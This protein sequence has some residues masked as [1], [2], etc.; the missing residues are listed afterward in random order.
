MDPFD[1]VILSSLYLS[2]LIPEVSSYERIR[3]RLP[4][5]KQIYD[6]KVH[7]LSGKGFIDKNDKSKLTFIGRDAIKVVLV[8]GVFD[9]IHPGH[10]HTLKA[11]KAHGDI[12]IVVIARTST[13]MKI[14][15]GRRIYHN[16]A[17][18]QELVSSLFFV[19]LAII[20]REGT[21]YDTVEF[22][23]PDVIALG[24]DQSH[25]EKEIAENCRRRNLNV[26]L[27]RLNTP[28]PVTKSSKIKDELGESFYNI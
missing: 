9:L 12:L 11:A 2:N 4:I 20:G 15:E 18:R 19:D 25:T 6:L 16:E 26:R 17:L 1:K 10:I 14:K 5:S 23:K 21:L 3:S 13:A 24:Y 27:I 28:I 8:G 7:E 22:V